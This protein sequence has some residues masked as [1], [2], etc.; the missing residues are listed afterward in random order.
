MA[1]RDIVLFADRENPVDNRKVLQEEAQW[2]RF[3][4]II[5]RFFKIAEDPS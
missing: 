4:S 3:T 1:A 2:H 5:E